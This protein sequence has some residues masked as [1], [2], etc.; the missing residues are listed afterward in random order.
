MATPPSPG[1]PAPAAGGGAEIV[2]A[3]RKATAANE[4]E[5]PYKHTPGILNAPS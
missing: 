2:H 1:G 4:V 3:Q 5:G